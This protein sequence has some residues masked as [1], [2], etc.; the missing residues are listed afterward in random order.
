M[1]TFY[2]THRPLI[3][4]RM[5]RTDDDRQWLA[6]AQFAKTSNGYWLAWR[7]DDPMRS[8]LF[9]PRQPAAKPCVWLTALDGI[10]AIDTLEKLVLYVE[11]GRYE[12][13]R[14]GVSL[15]ARSNAAKR[16]TL[17]AIDRFRRDHSAE[18]AKE[19]KTRPLR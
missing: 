9:D 15:H 5:A 10:N 6:S 8:A 19:M 18:A 16:R 12:T 1:A 3:A 4:E 13:D 11:A 2:R 17:E 7:A 14:S